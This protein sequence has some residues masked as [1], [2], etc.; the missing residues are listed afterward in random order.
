LDENKRIPFYKIPVIK[1]E[2]MRV[3]RSNC[4]LK[5][6]PPHKRTQSA[7]VRNIVKNPVK[8]HK[9]IVFDFESKQNKEL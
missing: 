8:D 6:K 2:E 7:I 9:H 4:Q 5:S 3:A 1:T